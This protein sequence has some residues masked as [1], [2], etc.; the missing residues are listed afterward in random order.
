MDE[1]GALDMNAFERLVASEVQV[2]AGPSRPTDVAAVVRTAA[3]E[4]PRWRFQSM[5]S[6]TKLVVAGAIV[7][8]S[9]GLLF[10]GLLTGPSREQVPPV[11]ASPTEAAIESQAV[12]TIEGLPTISI[13]TDETARFVVDGSGDHDFRTITAAVAAASAGDTIVVR[14]GTYRE[15]VTIDKDITLRGRDRD[16]V[17]IEYG[18]RCEED[19]DTEH[20]SCP[21][22]TPVYD[23]FLG[24]QRVFGIL[25]DST[26]A[27]ISGLTFRSKLDGSSNG[28]GVVVRGGAPT[29]GNI[30]YKGRA[31]GGGLIV[32]GGS[33][34]LIRD[35]EL[36][37]TV[38]R[39][40]ERSPV[41][42]ED[43]VF[44]FIIVNTSSSGRTGGPAT[45]RGNRTRGIA[46][47]GAALV[48]GNELVGSEDYRDQAFGSGIDV[49]GG[50]GWTIRDNVVRDFSDATA[51]MVA[52]RATGTIYR[53]TLTDN[54]IGISVGRSN[55]VIESNRDQ[56]W[57]DRHHHA[58]RI[59]IAHQQRRSWGERTRSRSRG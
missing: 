28:W 9:G 12:T 21:D 41:T 59:P 39:V 18:H 15:S 26:D 37:A 46:F 8:L 55:S 48:E 5:F 27:R 2:E 35:S 6:A 7:A 29:V 11:G 25:L 34:A 58:R 31:Q 51:I 57:R 3:T 47:N 44:E 56:R 30:A 13:A 10:T 52:P 50:D 19:P 14:P 43:S 32:H 23:G 17:I 45:I 20:H 36:G 33:S 22:D 4:S 42:V 38:I 53:N 54:R 40:G 49:E 1:R 24:R 16:R